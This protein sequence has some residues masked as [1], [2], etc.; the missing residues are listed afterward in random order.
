MLNYQGPLLSEALWL[1]NWQAATYV[2]STSFTIP[3][4]QASL[5][6]PGCS[7]QVLSAA[8]YFYS[9][10]V[11]STFAS[12]VTTVTIS[13]PILTNVVL[14]TRIAISDTNNN[15]LSRYFRE[16]QVIGPNGVTISNAAGAKLT[17]TVPG[18]GSNVAGWWQLLANTSGQLTLSASLNGTGT[19][20]PI[21][22]INTSATGS[23][24]SVQF[25]ALLDVATT[26]SSNNQ[27]QLFNHTNAAFSYSFYSD[28]VGE[29]NA[30]SRFWIAG[31]VSGEVT[32]GPRDGTGPM[33][34]IRL[35]AQSVQIENAAGGYGTG[36]EVWHSGNLNPAI[37]AVQGLSNTWV[38]G[39]V[40]PA[41]TNLNTVTNGWGTYA[42]AATN[43]PSTGGGIIST[44]SSVGDNN[45]PASGLNIFQQAYDAVSQAMF[46]RSNIANG[47]W[48]AWAQVF[49][50][51]NFNPGAYVP[52]AGNVT[53]AAP[54]NFTTSIAIQASAGSPTLN[55]KSVAGLGNASDARIVVTGGTSGSINQGALAINA[56]TVTLP[57]TTISGALTAAQNITVLG[58]QALFTNIGL[59]ASQTAQSTPQLVFQASSVSRGSVYLDTTGQVNI[60]IFN[61]SGTFLGSC[62]TFTTAGVT[63]P[64]VTVSQT[65]S[66]T[67]N[68]TTYAANTFNGYTI[69]NGTNA[70]VIGGR[71]AAYS[72]LAA[73]DYYSTSGGAVGVHHQAYGVYYNFGQGN[74]IS[75]NDYGDGAAVMTCHRG[76]GS[77]GYRFRST[78]DGVGFTSLFYINGSGQA[79]T[80]SD[81]KLKDVIAPLELTESLR[82]ISEVR[83]QVYRWKHN[84]E[85]D[86]GFIAQHAQKH[87]NR[88]VWYDE[89]MDQLNLDYSKVA[90]YHHEAI[91]HVLKMSN[92]HETDIQVLLRKVESLET[93]V[94]SL[95]SQ[96][97]VTKKLK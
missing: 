45:T 51:A 27:V 65:L 61:S 62:A 14:S 94:S 40:L 66:V 68:V 82:F 1:K 21:A 89:G 29:N 54:I 42:A 49:T 52:I 19:V 55:F 96:L 53:V 24:T 32:I 4:N 18:V 2:S 81:I 77:G 70:Y 97:V 71:P 90:V 44:I 34:L 43:K 85:I 41:Q 3:G 56:A 78:A 8:N 26:T 35:R 38:T 79:Y 64:N 6:Q 46:I 9:F 50:S 30:Q 84:G 20:Y 88:I 7:V 48:S 31:P 25:N 33:N 86:F 95:R 36:G 58:T 72:Y 91:N 22:L 63:T 87:A 16:A 74:Q 93:E 13:D 39:T 69:T 76:G 28:N 75:W 10:V 17:M 80:G 47:G 73:S 5:Y 23:P 57:A 12:N 37:Y 11:S 60:G 67:G 15:N 83:A 92:N 59:L